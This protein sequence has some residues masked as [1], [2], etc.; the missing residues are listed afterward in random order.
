MRL[1]W[2]DKLK[3]TP[4]KTLILLGTWAFHSAC[5]IIVELWLFEA[6]P[7]PDTVSWSDKS[8]ALRT[9]KSPIFAPNQKIQMLRISQNALNDS[10]FLWHEQP[11][12]NNPSAGLCIIIQQLTHGLLQIE[13]FSVKP[14]WMYSVSAAAY[15]PRC[16]PVFHRYLL[17]VAQLCN[18]SSFHYT[19]P[20]KWGI[21]W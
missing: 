7:K 3:S 1:G 19:S 21:G 20:T 5:Y 15:L 2:Q 11:V 10:S 4:W 13:D 12:Q 9:E 18:L 16:S 14:P 17:T 6:S 8:Y